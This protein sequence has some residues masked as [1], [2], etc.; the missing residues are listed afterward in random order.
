MTVPLRP[1]HNDSR[2]TDGAGLVLLRR[3]WDSDRVGAFLDAR[4]QGSGVRGRFRSGLMVEVWVVLLLYGGAV[5]DEL[6][7]LIPQ[8]VP[9]AGLEPE[10]PRQ[11]PRRRARSGL[12][13]PAAPPARAE[14]QRF[15][16]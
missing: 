13:P 9:G 1:R 2:V 10:G 4:G 11:R 14:A 6:K 12:R 16:S 7:G 5:M 8:Q 3:I 15:L